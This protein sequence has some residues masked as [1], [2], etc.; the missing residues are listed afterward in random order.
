VDALNTTRSGSP[1]V[2][3]WRAIGLIAAGTIAA[4]AIGRLEWAPSPIAVAMLLGLALSPFVR[5][6]ESSPV[7]SIGRIALRT[8]V[9]LLGFRI[10]LDEIA[11]LGAVTLV[12][13]VVV[14]VSVLTATVWLG[15]RTSVGRELA[16]LLGVGSAICGA[17][18]VAAAG[19]TIDSS[20][21]E[22]AYAIATV[23]LIG[24]VATFALPAVGSLVGLGDRDLGIWIGMMVHDVGQVVAASTTVGDAALTAAVPVKLVRVLLLVPVLTVLARSSLAPR[25]PVGDEHPRGLH[26]LRGLMPGFLALFILASIISSTGVIPEPLAEL[27]ADAE[28]ILFTAALFAIGVSVHAPTLRRIGPRPAFVSAAIWAVACATTLVILRA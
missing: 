15:R 27:A 20:D 7:S 14:S 13:A 11:G 1:N 17:S 18:A 23:T 26:R 16:T 8:G 4:T 6:G 19:T 25:R 5:L 9:V 3:L 21:E 10:T 12:M 24:T 28:K 2:Q 22:T